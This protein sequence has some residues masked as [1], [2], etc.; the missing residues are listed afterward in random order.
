MFEGKTGMDSIANNSSG[1]HDDGR[2]GL[3]IAA[4]PRRVGRVQPRLHAGSES[5]MIFEFFSL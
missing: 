4:A 3:K 2:P 5:G 1:R